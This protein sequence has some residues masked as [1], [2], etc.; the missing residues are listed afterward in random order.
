MKKGGNVSRLEEE[1]LRIIREAGD[2]GITAG[3]IA[4]RLGKKRTIH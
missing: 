4:H 2:V 3:Q 1:I